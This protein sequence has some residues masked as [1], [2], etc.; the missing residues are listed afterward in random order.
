[1][2][3]SESVMGLFK[4]PDIETFQIRANAQGTV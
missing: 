2:A 1:M 3:S 4:L